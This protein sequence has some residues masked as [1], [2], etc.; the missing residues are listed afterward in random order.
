MVERTK[1]ARRLAWSL[2]SQ[3]AQ[4]HALDGRTLTVAF[5]NGGSRDSFARNGCDEVLRQVLIDVLG[6]DWRVESIVDPTA[7]AGAPP[8]QPPPDAGRA[9]PA[10]PAAP[11][12]PPA[13]SGTAAAPTRPPL[14]PRPR[15]H[16]TTRRTPTTTTSRA[17]TTAP[18]SC[19]PAS[20][21]PG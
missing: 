2:L 1:S 11:A 15:P 17:A 13:G 20:S 7:E 6:V 19:S 3:S 10:A 5:V 4:V 9:D 18:R 16:P 21:G 12:A 14:G 8:P